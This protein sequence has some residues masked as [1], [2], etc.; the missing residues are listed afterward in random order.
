M[1]VINEA[2]AKKFFPD[3]DPVGHHFGMYEQ[4]D[5]GAYEIVGVVANAKYSDPHEAAKAMVFEPLAQWQHNLKEPIFVNL[6]TQTHHVGAVVM[7]FYGT[8]QKL[9]EAVWRTLAEID[10]NLAVISMRSLDAQLSGNFSQERMVARLTIVFG[11]L[12]LV[13]TSVGLY[14]ITAYQ[15][16]QRTREIGMR[17]AFGADRTRVVGMVMRGAFVQFSLGLLVGIPIALMGARMMGKQLYLVKSYDPWSLAVAILALA[18]AVAVAG[19]V[20]ARRA[21]SIDP[22]RALRNE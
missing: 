2:F 1:A 4:E 18:G 20:P 15:A 21:A 6:E 8:Q 17:M 5:M 11:L 22:M 16:T 3:E 13:L 14:G 10:P 7:E 19:F 12:A 9:E